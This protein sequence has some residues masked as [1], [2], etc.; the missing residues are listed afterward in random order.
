MQCLYV[1]VCLY[2][3][4]HIR[5]HIYMC[6]HV[7]VNGWTDGRTDSFDRLST[8]G[9]IQRNISLIYYVHVCFQHSG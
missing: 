1:C 2:I 4:P 9:H 6:K 5:A 7:C 3:H 8:L